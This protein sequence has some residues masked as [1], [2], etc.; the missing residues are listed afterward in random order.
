MG[1]ILL[2]VWDPHIHVGMSTLIVTTGKISLFALDAYIFSQRD[3][4]IYCENGH[5][6]AYIYVNIVIGVPIFT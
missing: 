6:D 5:P 4:H 2:F 3:A 1:R